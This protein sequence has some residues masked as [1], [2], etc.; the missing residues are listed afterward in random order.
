M[1]SHSVQ[2]P[3]HEHRMDMGMDL[4]IDIDINMGIINTLRPRRNRGHFGDDI[5][6]YTFSNENKWI[7]IEILLKFLRGQCTLLGHIDESINRVN[8]NNK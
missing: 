1:T 4:D 8:A 7:S 2:K 5:F 3:L 6:K